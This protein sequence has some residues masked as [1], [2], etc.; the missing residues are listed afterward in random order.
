[1]DAKKTN[2]AKKDVPA[3][4]FPDAPRTETLRAAKVR[5]YARYVVTLRERRV[6]AFN[7]P[8]NLF[9]ESANACNFR[10]A[11]CALSVPGK[12]EAR[13]VMEPA[14]MA[15]VAPFLPGL[16]NL[17]LHGF[18]EPL[19]NPELIPTAAAAVA[20]G[21]HVGFFTNGSL[22]DAERSECVVSARVPELTVSVSTADPAAYSRLYR[23][24]SFEKLE[25]NLQNLKR[26]KEKQSSPF[27]VVS[28]NMI[29]MRST[30]PGLADLVRFAANVGVRSIGVKPLVVYPGLDSMHHERLCYEPERDDPV[31]RE[32][33]RVA[34]ENGIGLEYEPYLRTER[35]EEE[36]CKPTGEGEGAG[37]AEPALHFSK[38]CP[39]VFSTM[40]VSVDGLVKPCCFAQ[41]DERHQPQEGPRLALGDASEQSLM[42]IWNGPEY[43][44]IREQHLALEVPPQCEHCFKF[45]LAPKWDEVPGWLSGHGLQIVNYETFLGHA[46]AVGNGFV[47][48]GVA[49]AAQG[50]RRVTE[51]L[52]DVRT[53]IDEMRPHLEYARDNARQASLVAAPWQGPSAAVA[54]IS[55]FVD[56]ALA[57]LRDVARIADTG[58]GACAEDALSALAGDLASRGPRLVV[59]ATRAL[60]EEAA[61]LSE[62]ARPE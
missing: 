7:T 28:F 57:G 59:M 14:M 12:R 44:R 23:G 17:S 25:D 11:F 33:A 46:R 58:L 6:E 32:A 2:R 22:L 53:L 51:G 26:E 5:N 10:C 30:L 62:E 37:E 1:M 34:S 29:A 15:A 48:A 18:G 4:S 42:D 16:A 52:W 35:Q 38:P 43:R 54:A 3:R 47:S 56:A 61:V 50:L 8:L 45:D 19:L 49:M 9:L 36:P 24:G 31:L 13:G 60:E 20:H 27:P 21:A 39:M 40:Y 55:E 41:G